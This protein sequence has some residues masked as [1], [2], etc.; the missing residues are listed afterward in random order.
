M[1]RFVQDPNSH[2]SLKDIQ[3]LINEKN[4][5][6]DIELSKHLKDEITVKWVSPLKGDNYS[7]YRDEDFL[8]ILGVNN[9]NIP[10]TNFW[11]KKG[12]Q[13]DALGR[14]N[15][16][17]FIV[18]AKANIPE[19]KSPKTKASGDSKILIEKSLNE[20]KKY[21]NIDISYNWLDKYYQ[22][23]NRI[24]HL[25]YLRVLN[26]LNAYLIFV[27]F[28]NDTSVNG[29]KTIEEWENEIIELHKKIGLKNDNLLSNFILDIFIDS[30]SLRL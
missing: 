13:W 25:Y 3:I 6:L 22:Y 8:N 7:E 30:N 1:G 11:P 20:V 15:N 17:L 29:P 23:I 24:A 26:R 2:G 21:L 19:L 18:E 10:L 16:K 4:D 12:P 9:I 14:Y 28:L 27:Y 5:I